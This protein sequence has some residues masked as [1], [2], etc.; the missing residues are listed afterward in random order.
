MTA[1]SAEAQRKTRSLHLAERG[2][3]AV[4]TGE[5]V[6]KGSLISVVESTG[7]V[8]CTAK[9]TGTA[10]VGVALET[11]TGNAAGSAKVDYLYG[12]V[13]LITAKAALTTTY[14]MCNVALEDDN[15]VT[16]LSDAG[17]A[18]VRQIVGTAI[19]FDSSGDAW[20]WVGHFSQKDA[21]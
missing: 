14:R 18:A 3:A 13:E 5:I 20:V 7:R 12:H 8:T 11:K 19:D 6:Y 9:T 15:T 4:K 16:T 1:L 10:F 2:N 17:T 21:P